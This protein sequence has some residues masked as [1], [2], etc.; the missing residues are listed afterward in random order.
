MTLIRLVCAA[1]FAALVPAVAR[2]HGGLLAQ[3]ETHALETTVPAVAQPRELS[4]AERGIRFLLLAQ[5]PDGSFG[6]NPGGRGEVGNTAIA[7]LAL[8]A[9]GNTPSR[10]PHWRELRRALDWV[11]R[12]TRGFADGWTRLDEQTLLHRKLGENADLYAVALFYSQVLGHNLDVQEEEVMQRELGNMVARIAALQKTNGEWETSYEPMLTTILAW[13]ALKQAHAAG[14][15]IPQASPQ[16]VVR[17]LR[18]DCLDAGGVFREQKW[19]RA[20]RFVTQAG[21][22][23]VLLGESLG[24]E[25]D[26]R[27]AKAKLLGMRFDQDVGS[28]TGGEE[29][30]GALFATQAFQLEQDGS[31][32]RWYPKIDKALRACQNKDG[33]WIGH[34]CLTG[35]VFCTACSVMALLT[36]DRLLPMIER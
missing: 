19:G 10:G 2:V 27:R 1:V 21:A 20:E 7:A 16:K 18:Q 28:H 32:E 33:S 6:D 26:V 4:A 31:H 22:V 30:L 25:P 36:P 3:V 9:H 17:Y 13:L 29:F 14:I 34:H 35:K 15:S 24:Q 12:R 11:R 5:N 23:R 8:M